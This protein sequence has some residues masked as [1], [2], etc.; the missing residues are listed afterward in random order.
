MKNKLFGKIGESLNANAFAVRL[1]AAMIFTGFFTYNLISDIKEK[2]RQQRL[3][4]L[5]QE[6]QQRQEQL[7]ETNEAKD[8]VPIETTPAPTT[9]PVSPRPTPQEEVAAEPVKKTFV[10]PIEG[11]KV[12][13][14][15]S[16]DE[17]VYNRTMDDWRTHN[18]IDIFA[19]PGDTVISGADGKVLEIV[20]DG[21]LGNVVVIQHEGFV[22]KYCGLAKH[23]FVQPGD[24]VHQGQSIG[25]VD[26]VPLEINDESHVHIEVI[27]DGKNINPDSLL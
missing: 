13:A 4:E 23:T 14:S 2:R 5:A 21:L 9:A 16:G 6:Q 22:A 11:G 24:N 18:G 3:Q 26:E 8:D 10:L 19:R 7:V 17:L 25:T 27:K 15:F 1:T 20:Q 12:Y